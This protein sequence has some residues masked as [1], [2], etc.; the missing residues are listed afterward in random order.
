MS[1]EPART[2]SGSAPQV[3]VLNPGLLPLAPDVFVDG[4]EDV[5]WYVPVEDE[6]GLPTTNL[7]R[8]IERDQGVCFFER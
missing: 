8:G 4:W 5:M 7:R 2:W 1:F 3:L 6:E